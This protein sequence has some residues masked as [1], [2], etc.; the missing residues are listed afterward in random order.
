[1]CTFQFPEM[2][3]PEQVLQQDLETLAWRCWEDTVENQTLN[4]MT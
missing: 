4:I 3:S 1:M 2:A